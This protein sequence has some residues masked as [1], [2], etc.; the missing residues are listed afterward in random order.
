MYLRSTVR[1]N[2]DGSEVRY[3]QLAENVWNSDKGCAVARV[4]YNFGRADGLDEQALRRLAASILRVLPSDQRSAGDQAGTDELDQR[5][6]WPY[7]A[8]HALRAIWLEMGI[9]TVM[10]AQ[11]RAKRIKQPLELALFAMVANRCLEPS[12]KL[13]CFE[14]WLRRR[15]FLPGSDKLTLQHLY[16]A[17]DLLEEHK[18]EVEK[19]VYFSVADLMNVD[20]DLIFYDT[21]S[22]H[23]EIDEE[24]DEVA[25]QVRSRLRATSQTR[26]S[27]E[28]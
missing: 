8:V 3:Y 13:H 15:V 14:H 12:S 25:E 7:G 5:G 16:A 20:V 1:H 11:L 27:E 4:V 23:F 24:D 21:T 18:A 10:D 6:C 26:Q 9:H 17:M 28:R 2:A 22:L 19:A